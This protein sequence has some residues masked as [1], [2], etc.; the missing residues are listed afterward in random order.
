MKLR[1]NVKFVK[2]WIQ[3]HIDEHK[4]E[5]DGSKVEDFVDIYLQAQRG[6]NQKL[7]GTRHISARFLGMG[8]LIVALHIIL[9]V[10]CTFTHLLTFLHW[11][12]SVRE[13]A[14]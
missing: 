14:V 8:Q 6:E 9:V 1:K 13:A 4:A 2:N 11:C 7:S 5:F 3:K 10:R 12:T